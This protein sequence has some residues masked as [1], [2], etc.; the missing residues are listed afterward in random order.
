MSSQLPDKPIASLPRLTSPADL[1]ANF[2]SGRWLERQQLDVP[3]CTAIC[4][5]YAREKPVFG[6]FRTE[7]MHFFDL[8]LAG[9][10][11]DSRGRLVDCF[12]EPQPLGDILFVPAGYRY[13]GGGSEGTQT[14]LFVFLHAQSLHEENARVAEALVSPQLR[15]FMS[16]RSDRIRFILTQISREMVNPDLGAYGGGAGYYLVGG[17][18]P[19]V[20][21]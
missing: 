12:H 16:L 11:A 20:E 9:R 17:N 13:Q 14:A 5:R 8:S 3:S 18:R 7:T 15:D 6:G 4:G 19:L 2:N 10:T 1:K 21:K